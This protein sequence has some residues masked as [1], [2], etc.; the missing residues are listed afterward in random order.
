MRMTV[1]R[2]GDD[3]EEKEDERGM[4]SRK[5][6]VAEGALEGKAWPRLGKKRERG[7]ERVTASE[8]DRDRDAERVTE[9]RCAKRRVDGALSA[10]KKGEENQEGNLEE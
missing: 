8:C 6:K 5:V 3:D 7:R 10:C 9:K 4:A 2:R 1:R